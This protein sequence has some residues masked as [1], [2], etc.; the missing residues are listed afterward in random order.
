MLSSQCFKITIHNK[1]L[2]LSSI[3]SYARTHTSHHGLL[4]EVKSPGAVVY[5]LT[6]IKKAL[7]CVSSFSIDA[8]Y[9]RAGFLKLWSSGSALVVLLH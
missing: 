2:R 4:H 1:T 9:T 5:R 7:L 8:E 3:C 6:S